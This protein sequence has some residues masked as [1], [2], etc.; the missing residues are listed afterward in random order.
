MGLKLLSSLIACARSAQAPDPF[1]GA[2]SNPAAVNFF[3]LEIQYFLYLQLNTYV[4]NEN[5]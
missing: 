3:K 5:Q 1:A 2:G 4:H